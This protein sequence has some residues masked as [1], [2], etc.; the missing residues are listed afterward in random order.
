[1]LVMD[2]FLLNACIMDMVPQLGLKTNTVS[3]QMLRAAKG[4]AFSLQALV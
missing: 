3:E 2:F 1:M 4:L